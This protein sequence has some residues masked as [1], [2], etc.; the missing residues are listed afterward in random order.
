MCIRDSSISHITKYNN[1]YIVG[2]YGNGLYV[3][4]KE[5]N[6]VNNVLLGTT[7]SSNTVASIEKDSR[8]HYWVSTFDGIAILDS[9]FRLIE[10]LFQNQGLSYN[11]FNRIASINVNNSMLFGNTNGFVSIN[12]ELYYKSRVEAIPKLDKIE[13]IEDNNEIVHIIQNDFNRIVGNP[14]S[15]TLKYHTPSFDI[16]NTNPYL[17]RKNITITPEADY[18]VD[19]KSITITNPRR[20]HYKVEINAL[21]NEQSSPISVTNL[22]VAADTSNWIKLLSTFL[23]AIML[24]LVG[25]WFIIQN[26]QQKAKK[27]IALNKKYSEIK[28]Q[29][30]RS[31]LNPHFVFNALSSIQY[32]IQSNEKNM[33]RAY[34]NKF[35]NL[36]R[37]TLESSH[38]NIIKL[39]QEIKQISLYL[40]LELLRFE[41]R[42][43]YSIEI[44]EDIDP[45]QISIPSMLIQPLVENSIKHGLSSTLAT[46]GILKIRIESIDATLKISVDDNGIGRMASEKNKEKKQSKHISLSTTITEERI[47]MMNQGSEHNIS[48]EYIDKYDKE[49][50]ATGTTAIIYLSNLNYE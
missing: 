25:A 45:K 28:L 24:C 36:M 1:Q 19:H 50:Q 23:L 9:Q 32:Y 26:I 43:C 34:L 33:A 49:G 13:V 7:L 20:E 8:G 17:D 30:L 16:K 48:L 39:S 18:K 3:L 46:K 35:S 15:I 10:T 12:P 40:E 6:P 44:D 11:E 5:F 14:K 42:W 27:E 22:Q 4:D 37:L 21:I 38:F 47:S 31:Q 29:A 2:T 41:D